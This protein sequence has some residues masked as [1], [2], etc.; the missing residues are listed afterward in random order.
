M[1][2]L[3]PRGIDMSASAQLLRDDLHIDFIDGASA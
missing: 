1:V 3:R 2:K